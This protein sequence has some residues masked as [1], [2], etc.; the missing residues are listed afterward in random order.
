MNPSKVPPSAE[1]SKSIP[2]EP[3]AIA[4]DARQIEGNADPRRFYPRS[5]P[6]H[7]VRSPDEDFRMD[8]RGWRIL[9]DQILTPALAKGF[10]KVLIETNEEDPIKPWTSVLYAAAQRLAKR[11]LIT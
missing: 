5:Q 3:Q 9:G 6:G 8:S 10:Q 1:V 2:T 11:L 4:G 7:P